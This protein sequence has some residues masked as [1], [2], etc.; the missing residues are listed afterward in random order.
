MDYTDEQVRQAYF[1]D[2][3]ARLQSENSGLFA[4]SNSRVA[5]YGTAVPDPE[6]TMADLDDDLV[7]GAFTELAAQRGV[8]ITELGEQILALTGGERDM[9]S[10]A[11][12]VAELAAM[13]PDE[14]GALLDLAAKGTKGWDDPDE[15]DETDEDDEDEDDHPSEHQGNEGPR[16]KKPRKKKRATRPVRVRRRGQHVAAEGGAPTGGAGPSGGGAYGSEG[17]AMAASAPRRALV[18]AGDGTYGTIALSE[19]EQW[20]DEEV[21]RLQAEHTR[22]GLS[23]PVFDTPNDLGGPQRHFPFVI[24]D[25]GARDDGDPTDPDGGNTAAIIARLQRDHN[26]YFSPSKAYGANTKGKR[27]G[28]YPGTGPSG[29]PQ[30]VR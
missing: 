4:F 24:Y 23:A 21:A 22:V 3:L 15:E 8:S 29:K 27:A 25:V 12:A 6:P 14:A 5:S 30:N 9:Q 16:P 10:R 28:K 17:G 26:E 2:E 11:L 7:D 1:S 18:R 20:A 13:P 19:D